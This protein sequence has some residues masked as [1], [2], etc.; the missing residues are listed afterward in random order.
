MLRQAQHITRRYTDE[1][2]TPALAKLQARIDELE[3]EVKS[4]RGA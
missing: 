1:Q 4:L 3:A 2:I